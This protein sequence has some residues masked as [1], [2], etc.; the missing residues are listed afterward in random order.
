[1]PNKPCAIPSVSSLKRLASKPVEVLRSAKRGKTEE[2]SNEGI[3]TGF[4]IPFPKKQPPFLKKVSFQS[5]KKGAFRNRN[6]HF[7]IALFTANGACFVGFL[8][9]CRGDFC[10]FQKHFK[11][12]FWEGRFFDD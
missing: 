11:C 12:C 9:I 3:C 4:L 1:M 6:F 5:C 2:R 10:R 8:G 7:P